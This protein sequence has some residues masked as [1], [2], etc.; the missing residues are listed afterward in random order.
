MAA[1]L[2]YITIASLLCLLAVIKNAHGFTLCLSKTNPKQI[3]L[4][5][6][7]NG[8]TVSWTTDGYFNQ[9]DT[10]TPQ[11]RYGTD[12]S[13]LVYTSPVGFTTT[14]H[15]LPIFKKFFHNVYLDGLEPSKRYY[16]QIMATNKCVRESSIRSFLTA[17]SAES[18]VGYPVNISVVGDLGLNNVFNTYQ[19]ENTIAV[20][21]NHVSNSNF[22]M[23]IGDIAYADLYGLIVNIDLYE[24]IWN[25]FQQAIDP[26]A[27]NVCYQVLPGNHE[28]TCFQYSDAV[29]PSYLRNFTAY[30]NR[31]CMSGELSGGYRN[32]WYS[33]DYGPVHVIMLNTETDFEKAPGGPGTT[34]NGGHFFNTTAQ[35]DWLRKDLEKAS[36]PEQRAKV[37]WIVAAAHR[38][39]FG[40]PVKATLELGK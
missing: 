16:Y 13:A 19:A 28:V 18:N 39:F 10:P 17:P 35:Q 11:V 32:M 12:P 23:H 24:N 37:P 29:C 38:P 27:S 26:I 20:M 25:R 31:F 6:R 4:A 9:N 22:F 1:Q 2:T 7:P 15:P 40:S 8:I 30:N 5:L 34:L 33:F 36:A 21:K 3:R 14:Y